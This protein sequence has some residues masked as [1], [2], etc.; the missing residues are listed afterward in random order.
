MKKSYHSMVVPTR[1]AVATV[2]MSEVRALPPALPEL[3]SKRPS[4]NNPNAVQPVA[5]L[6]TPQLP[7]H[8]RLRGRL[9][10]PGISV[11]GCLQRERHDQGQGTVDSSPGRINSRS[12][13]L[14]Y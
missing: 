12:G 14:A 13:A 10:A 7:L 2:L 3:L 5:P 8:C 4:P 11:N 1:L 6:E 9:N